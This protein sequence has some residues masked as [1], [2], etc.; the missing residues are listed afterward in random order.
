MLRKVHKKAH[1]SL[2]MLAVILRRSKTWE[3]LWGFVGFVM[4][5]ALVVKVAEPHI[6][7]YGDALWYCYAVVTTVGF[8]DIT[9]TSLVARLVSVVLSAYAVLVIAVITGV[10]V[11]FYNEIA[12]AQRHESLS[13]FLDEL[14][15]LPEL[16]DEELKALSDKIKELR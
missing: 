12:E 14:E 5:S 13:L 9:V 10:V 8:G 6:A 7:T 11:D 4:V 15:K 1:G 16:S 2:H 3:V